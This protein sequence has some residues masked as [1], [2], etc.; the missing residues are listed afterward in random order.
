VTAVLRPGRRADAVGGR[1]DNCRQPDEEDVDR[2]IH[3]SADHDTNV[4]SDRF[5][6]FGSTANPASATPMRDEPR[7]ADPDATRTISVDETALFGALAA[8]NYQA[9]VT[10]IGPTA[11]RHVPDRMPSSD[12]GTD[13]VGYG[14]LLIV[15]ET[16]SGRSTMANLP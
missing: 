12:S 2:R 11:D 7:E 10:A 13:Q 5:D 15:L 4:T 8:G 14:P 1:A 16:D 3:A 9:T 6:V